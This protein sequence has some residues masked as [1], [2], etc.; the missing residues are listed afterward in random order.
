M[1]APKGCS[2]KLIAR[3]LHSQVPTDR[4]TG[5]HWLRKKSSDAIAGSTGVKM[6]LEICRD[7][8]VCMT[9]SVTQAALQEE[10]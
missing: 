1:N 8:P 2:A 9:A 3:Q 7:Q 6:Q 10:T 5:W 4:A